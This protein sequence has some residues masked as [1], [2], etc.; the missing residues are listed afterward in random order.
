[1]ILYTICPLEDIFEEEEK[2]PGKKQTIEVNGV[3]L[4]VEDKG[5]NNYEIVQL[6]SSNPQDFLDGRYQPGEK[7]TMKPL[8]PSAT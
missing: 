1:M 3:K 8:L 6:I 2:Q 7:L 4:I 5:D